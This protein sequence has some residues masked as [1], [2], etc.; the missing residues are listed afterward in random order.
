MFVCVWGDQM[1]FSQCANKFHFGSLL[2]TLC[3]C[4]RNIF[5][6]SYLVLVNRGSSRR[7]EEWWGQFNSGQFRN[8]QASP[9]TDLTNFYKRQNTDDR[10]KLVKVII[11]RLIFG[12]SLKW[13]ACCL[14][15]LV[16]ADESLL[17]DPSLLALSKLLI[18]TISWDKLLISHSLLVWR[19]KC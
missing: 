19:G 15:E 5:S 4:I 14:S 8:H 11:Q 17:I 3:S 10:G 7:G 2:Q 1:P 18:L 6:S 12:C 9:Q 16:F 13:C